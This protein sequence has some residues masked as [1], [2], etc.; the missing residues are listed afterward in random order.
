MLTEKQGES[1]MRTI[2]VY[3]SDGDTITTSINGTDDEIVNHYLGKTF[4]A[5]CDTKYHTAL[6]VSFHDTTRV[7]GLRVKN[8][9]SGQMGIVAKI[10]KETTW[11]DNDRSTEDIIVITQGGAHYD[12]KDLW[13]YDMQG[14]WIQGIGYPKPFAK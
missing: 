14:E 8:I 9:E 10:K 3:M 11:I 1:T 13:V 6:S 4:E 12:L 5:G 7:V 2:T